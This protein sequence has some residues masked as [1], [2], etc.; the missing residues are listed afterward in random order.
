MEPLPMSEPQLPRE[1]LRQALTEL[2]MNLERR[3]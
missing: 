1:V 3:R 2:A